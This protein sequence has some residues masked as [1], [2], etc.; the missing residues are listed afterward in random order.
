MRIASALHAPPT[1]I[2]QRAIFL[3]SDRLDS[4][5]RS[6]LEWKLLEGKFNVLFYQSN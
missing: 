5:Q 3:L 1:I 2:I 4:F 6:L